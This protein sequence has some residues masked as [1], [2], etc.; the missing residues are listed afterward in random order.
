[1]NKILFIGNVQWG[2]KPTGGGA[3]AKNQIFWRYISGHYKNAIMYDT[4][5]KSSIIS[6]LNIL[7]K[8]VLKAD[9]KDVIIL[10]ISL[11]GAYSIANILST[12]NVKR[13][14]YYWV[15][16]G[17]IVNSLQK[18][19]N[20]SCL[21]YFS[22]IVV[23]ADYISDGLKEFGLTNVDVIRNFKKIDYL[24]KYK[25]ETSTKIRFVYLA[26]L[27]PEKGVD[28]IIEAARKL[29]EAE[30]E[31]D[32]YGSLGKPYT[33]NYF[34]TLELENVKYCGF[35]D[36]TKHENYNI[37]SNYDVMLF[38]TF[39]EGEG[40]PGILIDAFIAG[41]PVIVSDFH[42]NPEVVKDGVTGFIVP[43]KSEEALTDRMRRLI[44]NPQIINEL[45]SNCQKEAFNYDVNVV[46]DKC[47]R[48]Y[49]IEMRF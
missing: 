11:R 46:L 33:E 47:F 44:S 9:K 31:I 24:P 45:R 16:G 7:M 29:K 21:N 6:L 20:K 5:K 43:V 35:L 22:K 36:L 30:F 14:I 8:I 25:K 4:W 1:M 48:D 28:L 2:E 17:D 27:I 40:F 19:I 26:R 23:Q 37:L 12:I 34:K 3:Q 39:F 42:A 49:N 32:F 18:K 13:R 15:I 41:L 38:P 10:S